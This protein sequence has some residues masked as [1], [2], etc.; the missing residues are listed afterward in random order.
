MWSVALHHTSGSSDPEPPEVALERLG[1][2]P[3]DLPGVRALPAGGHLHLVVTLVG[4][5]GQM[6]HVGDVDHVA[7]PVALP[8]KARLT[9]SA[10]T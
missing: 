9:V 7:H 10:K 6:A 5:G 3:G 2:A 4:V 1:V 8:A